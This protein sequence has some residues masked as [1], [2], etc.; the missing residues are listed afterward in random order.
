VRR[1]ICIIAIA[2]VLL[3][4]TAHAEFSG[5]F[6]LGTA[7]IFRG[8]KQ[9]RDGPAVDGLVQYDFDNGFYSAAWAGR[10]ELPI[11]DEG[12]DV[13]VD[14]IIGFSRA[15]TPRASFD[16]TII[17]YTYPTANR[18]QDYDWTEWYTSA[19][20]FEHWSVGVGIGRDWLGAGETTGNAEL[21]FRY[22]LPLG[23]VADLTGGYQDVSSVLGRDYTYYEI[24]V[25]R[26]LRA[27]QLR[28]AVVGSSSAAEEIFRDAAD[29]RWLGTL[30]W[31][32]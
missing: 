11:S 5:R 31:V 32:F 22:P 9:T 1:A 7:E 20:L 26:F 28:V 8:I 23:L 13:E 14:Y 3:G 6:S 27:F 2:V 10:V 12:S 21:T 29:A 19:H 15:L 16:S 4:R 30:T 25:G 18:L 17:H 24:G